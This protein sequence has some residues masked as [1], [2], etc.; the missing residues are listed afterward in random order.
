MARLD[1]SSIVDTDNRRNNSLT[2]LIQANGDAFKY[3]ER[4]AGDLDRRLDGVARRGLRSLENG[5][6][7][8]ITGARSA[9]DSLRQLAQTIL[10]DLTQSVIG[11]AIGGGSGTQSLIAGSLTNIGSS[12]GGSSGT[13]SLIAGSLT[14]VISSTLQHF[15]GQPARFASG[16]LVASSLAR[17]G[18]DRV[19][20]L[21]SPGEFVVNARA[22][23]RWGALLET[24]N[25]GGSVQGG[26]SSGRGSTFF[27]IDAR[28]AEAGSEA[29]IR[30]VVM[31]TLQVHRGG[32]VREASAVAQVEFIRAIERGGSIASVV[33]RR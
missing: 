25:R 30:D 7:A 14:N 5:L 22:T 12:I 23:Q 8:T 27:S 10:T 24:I 16:G 11:S 2:D 32:I 15:L 18:T 17:Q 21:L 3:L 4:Q 9:S 31:Q 1:L 29:R 19:P 20:A 6:I 13:Q 26:L 28:G 33:G